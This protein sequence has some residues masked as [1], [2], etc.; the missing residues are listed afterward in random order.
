MPR[1][2]DTSPRRTR[3]TDDPESVPAA[4]PRRVKACLVLTRRVRSRLFTRGSSK[5][6]MIR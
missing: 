5:G 3:Q 6:G 1:L 4:Q 2:N